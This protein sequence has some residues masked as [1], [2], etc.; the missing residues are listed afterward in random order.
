MVQRPGVMLRWSPV[1]QGTPGCGKGTISQAVAYCHGRKNVAHPSPD[2]IA[3]DFNGYMHQKTLIVVNEIG[4]HSKR[5]LSVL[6]E[7]IK[8]WDHRRRRPHS[9]QG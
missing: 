7:K 5:E 6:S 2:V 9:R 3:T 8:P 4:D 1:M